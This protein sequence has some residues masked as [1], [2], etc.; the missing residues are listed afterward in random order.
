MTLDEY[1]KYEQ[2]NF[3]EPEGVICLHCN[4]LVISDGPRLTDYVRVFHKRLAR[5]EETKGIAFPAETVDYYLYFHP[6][7]FRDIAGLSYC[8]E[9]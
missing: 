8:I 3:K 2:L 4:K 5:P 7:C 9:E 6:E 1:K